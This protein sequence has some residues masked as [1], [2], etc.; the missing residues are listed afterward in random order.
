M[1]LILTQTVEHLGAAGELV[2]VKNGYARNYL[3]PNGM[4]VSATAKNKRKLE[5]DRKAISQRVAK[6]VS[7]AQS[8]A[9]RING[10][11]LQF[12]RQVGEDDKMFGSVTSRDLA[13]QLEVAGVKIDSK[14]IQLAE[15]IKAIGKYDVPVKIHPSVECKLTFFVVGKAS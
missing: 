3:L 15:P 8:M 9:D 5:H 1:Q 7:S 10:M 11:R 12:E 2:Q 6:E 13:K 4:A 14:K